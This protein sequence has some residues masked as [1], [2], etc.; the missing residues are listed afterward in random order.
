MKQKRIE[1]R[2]DCV[3]C[4][5]KAIKA[6]FAAC[7]NCGKSRGVDTVFYL[8]DNIDD[9]VLTEEQ[10][11]KTTNN[12]DWLCE[13]CDSYNRADAKYCIT[14]GASKDKSGDDYATLQNKFK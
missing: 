13:Y 8:P 2:W 9:S 1:G 6:R 4:G 14:C 10:A 7:P 11:A 5:S 3:F 12:P